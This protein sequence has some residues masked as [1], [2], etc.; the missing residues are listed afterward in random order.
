MLTN[1][2]RPHSLVNGVAFVKNKQIKRV[3]VLKCVPSCTMFESTAAQL[4]NQ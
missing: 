1:L 2:D 4:V 3:C